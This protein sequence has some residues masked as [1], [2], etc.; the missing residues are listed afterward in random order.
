MNQ[1]QTRQFVLS[2]LRHQDYKNVVYTN[3][4]VYAEGDIPIAL[5]AHSDTVF[6]TPPKEFFHD[7]EQR[8]LWSPQGMGADDKAGVLM[9]IAIIKKYN[10]KPH[11]IVTANEET[12]CVGAIK[13]VKKVPTCP[14]KECKYLIQ[15]DRRGHNDCVF[16]DL[17][18][19]KFEEYIES[20][21]FKT[22][23]GS[24][25][26]IST[27]APAWGIGAVNLSVG[28]ED[29]HSYTERLYV[30][31]WEETL[32]KVIKMLK[33]AGNTCQWGYTEKVYSY[34][35]NHIYGANW[36]DTCD[37]CNAPTD[38]ADLLPVYTPDNPTYGLDVCPECF[39]KICLEMSW[40]SKCNKAWY[41][42][43]QNPKDWVCPQCQ[44]KGATTNAAVKVNPKP[45][46]D[47]YNF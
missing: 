11:I 23:W 12:G 36:E 45:P 1:I 25:S 16:Y 24:F 44:E 22:Q 28:Y 41:G 3:D 39:A 4:Y 21:G 2:F 47:S 33:D 18:D 40:C 35:H 43:G 9:M 6:K 42:Y 30:A 10:L 34:Y 15:L 14:F 29:E 31:W 37:C 13:L 7:Q 26:D 17:D 19:I 27:I 32:E 5:V 8:I 38:Y 46:K 20:F